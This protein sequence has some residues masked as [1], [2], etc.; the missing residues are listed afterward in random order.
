M[1]A[2]LAPMLGKAVKCITFCYNDRGEGYKL[3][4]NCLY[5]NARRS[6]EIELEWEK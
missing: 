5:K 4:M 1:T 2:R 3:I 6:C